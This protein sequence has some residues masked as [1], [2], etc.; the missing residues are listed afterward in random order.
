V[1]EKYGTITFRIL[2]LVP[3]LTGVFLA[4][5]WILPQQN[6]RDVVVAYRNIEVGG[7]KFNRSKIPAGCRFFTQNNHSFSL[8]GAFVNQPD[9][10]LAY[11]PIFKNVTAVKSDAEDYTKYLISGINGACLW[12]VAG[13][14]VSAIGSLL[15][16]GCYKN[17]SENGFINIILFN[18]LVAFYTIYLLLLH[19]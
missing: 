8:E 16:M 9:V 4:D 13:L 17:L 2:L 18:G 5:S 19:N 11:S 15:L 1:K 7:G 12:F 6:T 10:M 14:S 3:I